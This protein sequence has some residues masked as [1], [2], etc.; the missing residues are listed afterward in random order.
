MRDAWQACEECGHK[1]VRDS[2]LLPGMVICEKCGKLQVGVKLNMTKAEAE[3]EIEIPDGFSPGIPD[4]AEV[5]VGWRAWK[6]N[7]IQGQPWLESC[8]HDYTWQPRTES[9]AE[10]DGSYG[11]CQKGGRVPGAKCS[12]GFY[13]TKGRE[14]LMTTSYQV[15]DADA[16][17][18][19]VI[20][21]VA[22]WGELE[23]GTL[24]WRAELSYPM[25]LYL[26]YEGWKHANKLEALYG[27]PVLLNNWLV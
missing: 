3:S 24:G 21:K 26:P 22:N 27:K 25:E 14:H 11:I 19:H 20:G 8:V 15:Y 18:Y 16:G 13:S 17:E 10:C 6:L 12:C 5:M 7:V 9:L 4:Y 1:D 23:E 2:T